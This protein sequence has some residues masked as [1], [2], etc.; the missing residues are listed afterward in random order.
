MTAFLQRLLG[1]P[2][3]PAL[4]AMQP[5]GL[6][7][8]PLARAD[9]RLHDPDLVERI[10]LPTDPGS[11]ERAVPPSTSLFDGEGPSLGPESPST[12]VSGERRPQPP[13]P[14]TPARRA[15]GRS[16]HGE[17]MRGDPRPAVDPRTAADPM[18]PAS[19]L[20]RG[21]DR[22]NLPLAAPEA[23]RLIVPALQPDPNT[24]VS[25]DAPDELPP[26]LE[27]SAASEHSLFVDGPLGAPNLAAVIPAPEQPSVVGP[28]DVVVNA[29][30]LQL[31]SPAIDADRPERTMR[32]V[33]AA[34]ALPVP[35]AVPPTPAIPVPDPGVSVELPADVAAAVDPVPPVV[36][37]PSPPTSQAETDG[38][39]VV[40]EQAP[41]ARPATASSASRIG[42]LRSH[43][44]NRSFQGLRRR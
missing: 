31:E 19:P 10:P 3:A 37:S 6:S 28:V 41:S 40:A 1:A 34:P 44:Q 30:P 20:T 7:M 38:P 39:R 16:E 36:S 23:A 5:A 13:S 32:E 22:A 29:G 42:P 11:R 4:G 15:S 9:Q 26:R 35:A 12:P 43:R 25:V 24:R 33:V 8:S 21:D 18:I 17:P 14:L 2:A 27:L